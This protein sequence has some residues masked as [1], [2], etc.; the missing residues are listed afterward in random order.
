MS[1]AAG[2]QTLTGAILDMRAMVANAPPDKAAACN[3]AFQS[4]VADYANAVH[5]FL[6]APKPSDGDA[7]DRML[8]VLLSI[9]S[10]AS[11]LEPLIS[12]QPPAPVPGVLVDARGWRELREA[13]AEWK[14]LRDRALAF[15]LKA[16]ADRIFG[17]AHG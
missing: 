11:E 2:L 17:G 6:K 1:A 5:D 8:T 15:G 14:E 12:F 3:A 9:A 13:V 7:A 4:A 16:A 10:L